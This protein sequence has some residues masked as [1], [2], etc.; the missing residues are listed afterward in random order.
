MGGEYNRYSTTSLDMELGR[1]VVERDDTDSDMSFKSDEPIKAFYSDV[2]ETHHAKFHHEMSNANIEMYESKDT[3]S[4]TMNESEDWRDLGYGIVKRN[5]HLLPPKHND[6]PAK[7]KKVFGYDI[8][9]DFSNLDNIVNCGQVPG[10]RIPV[11]IVLLTAAQ[12]AI[13]IAMMVKVGVENVTKNV[14]IGP[15]LATV[16]AWGGKDTARI[17]NN[18]EVYRLI[19][20]F[21]FHQGIIHLVFTLMWQLTML[22]QIERRWGSLRVGFIYILSGIGGN[23]MSAVFLPDSITVGATSCLIGIMSAM[24]AETLLD[25]F[26]SDLEWPWKSL[27]GLVFQVGLFL[28]LGYIPAID[29]FANFGGVWTGFFASLLVTSR[30]TIPGFKLERY[31][32][33]VYIVLRIFAA[34][35]LMLFY[36]LFFGM[37]FGNMKWKCKA[38]KL[39]HPDWESFIN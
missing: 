39:I 14:M 7:Q 22:V 17:K 23:L 32:S 29:N 9:P 34:L 24:I 38:C 21:L 15:P 4:Q 25:W 6:K 18:K 13:L 26:V 19:T 5:A 2:V 27:V 3:T 33:K 11:F 1:F 20:P 36:G 8:N 31:M 37:L 28:V 12:V 10:K 35:M 16:N 30:R